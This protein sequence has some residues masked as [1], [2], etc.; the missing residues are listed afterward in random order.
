MKIQVLSRLR[1]V[2]TGI[3]I[4]KLQVMMWVFQVNVDFGRHHSNNMNCRGFK[5]FQCNFAKVLT[6]LEP[7]S[8]AKKQK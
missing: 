6:Q 7:E 3:L 8:S 5:H 1:Q 4:S 2:K